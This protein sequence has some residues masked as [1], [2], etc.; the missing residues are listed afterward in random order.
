MNKRVAEFLDKHN[1][2]CENILSS[3]N[4]DLKIYLIKGHL[5]I[6]QVFKT[7]GFQFFVPASNKNDIDAEFS[8]VEKAIE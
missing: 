6:L 2:R 8:A 7:Q 5:V 3:N 1:A 4:F